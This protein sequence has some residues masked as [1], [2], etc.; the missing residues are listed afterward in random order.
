MVDAALP[1]FDEQILAAAPGPDW[2]AGM[3]VEA[4]ATAMQ[5]LPAPDQ[6]AEDGL[7][8]EAHNLDETKYIRIDRNRGSIEHVN[9]DRLFDWSTSSLVAVPEA[10]A[11]DVATDVL[12]SLGLPDSE[13]DAPDVR[14]MMGQGFCGEDASPMFERERLVTVL[15]TVNGYPVYLS[16]ARVAVSNE[17]ERASLSVDWPRFQLRLALQLRARQQIVDQ[18]AEKMF[19]DLQGIAGQVSIEL[20]YARAGTDF[21]PAA[22]AWI[23]D[24]MSARG[25]IASLAVTEPD[26]DWDGVADESDNCP[27]YPNGQQKDRD[28]DGVGDPCDNCR[29]VANPLQDDAD[30][31]GNGDACSDG[32][33][34]GLTDEY[35]MEHP[36][37]DPSVP[38]D[39]TDADG[40]GLANVA[41]FLRGTNPCATDSDGDEVSDSVDNCPV[42]PNPRQEDEDGDGLGN[43]CDT[44][45]MGGCCLPDGSCQVLPGYWC[46]AQMGTLVDNC[47][48]D[49][50]GDGEDDACADVA[51]PTVS[52]WGLI[53]LALL[54]LVWARVKFYLRRPSQR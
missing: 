27:D 40:D 26:A 6:I 5:D 15:R 45:S 12:D 28:E 18:I 49:L 34:D 13:R 3:T 22:V 19:D 39:A 7:L 38:D 37:L 54:L 44:L 31:D 24:S 17:G 53:L 30:G 14:A 47:H 42:N 36:C 50:D 20:A 25:F 32:D 52:G 2:A 48:G 35:E 46:S 1:A 8:V 4:V 11:I 29:D 10:V 9:L 23:A 21:L 16:M 41:E 51:I 33:G 43:D